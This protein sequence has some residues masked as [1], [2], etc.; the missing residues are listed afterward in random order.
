MVAY[1]IGVLVLAEPFHPA[2]LGGAAAIMIAV[3]YE[4]RAAESS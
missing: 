2:V 4:I 3:A 1:L